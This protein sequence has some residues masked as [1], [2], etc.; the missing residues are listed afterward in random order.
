MDTPSTQ[1]LGQ[2][3]WQTKWDDLMTRYDTA[4]SLGH[5]YFLTEQVAKHVENLN[6]LFSS[7]PETI[8]GT[9][10]AYVN[11]VS[12]IAADP[13]NTEA[14]SPAFTRLIEAVNNIPRST[15][16]P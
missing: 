1:T 8:A 16:L 2:S 4:V 13:W 5:V 15:P 9:L 7:Q 12:V 6:D 11:A 10:S 14:C 3:Q